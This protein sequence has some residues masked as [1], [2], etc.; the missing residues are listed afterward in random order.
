[1]SNPAIQSFLESTRLPCS[2]MALS[3]RDAPLSPI[4]SKLGGI[5]YLPEGAAP[6]LDSKGQPMAFLAQIRF[7]DVVGSALP[8]PREGLLQFWVSTSVGVH[9]LAFSSGEKAFAAVH[10]P[11]PD[12]SLQRSD[13]ERV[14]PSA[15]ESEEARPFSG[16]I[17]C[18]FIPDTCLWNSS[19]EAIQIPE[20]LDDEDL[21]AASDDTSPMADEAG[22][23]LLH[24]IGG[25]PYF[26]QSDVRPCDPTDPNC[27]PESRMLLLWQCDS[28][29][30]AGILWGD[31]GIANAFIPEAD[32]LA[33]PPRFDRILWN[34]DCH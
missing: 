15:A 3:R 8:L 10:Y 9:G 19:E 7:P 29:D 5:P 30:P 23:S 21:W 28:D 6:P 14:L 11:Q 22:A 24:R 20:G 1:M 18:S 31:M 33:T 4:A 2:R 25:H 26:T 32:L 27:P 12:L 34:W 17:A 13:A 16:E